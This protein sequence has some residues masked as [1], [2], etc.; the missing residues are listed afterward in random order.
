MPRNPPI[1]GAD[2]PGGGRFVPYEDADGFGG[3]AWG[4][5][6]A[7]PAPLCAQR[8]LKNCVMLRAPIVSEHWPLPRHEA[9]TRRHLA[10]L[11]PKESWRWTCGRSHTDS[12][13]WTPE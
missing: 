11:L 2:G 13:S 9:M 10:R 3:A 8:L 4:A 5:L 7:V 6:A 1:G 12:W